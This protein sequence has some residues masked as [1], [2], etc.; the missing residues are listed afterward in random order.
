MCIRQAIRNVQ[1]TAI[2]PV[3]LF[4]HRPIHQGRLWI[5]GYDAYINQEIWLGHPTRRKVERLTE[6][7]DLLHPMVSPPACSDERRPHNT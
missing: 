2:E 5:D 4:L 3:A 6:E 1:G 7:Y